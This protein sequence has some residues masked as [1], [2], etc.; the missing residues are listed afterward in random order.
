MHLQD[1]RYADYISEQIK[2]GTTTCAL[3]CKDG[4]VLAADT[5]ASAGFFIADRH[6]MK[7]QKVDRHLGMT[8]AGGVA[9]AQNLVDV[10][11]YNAN[12]YRIS[13]REL[14]PVSSAARLCSNVLFNQRYFPYYVQIILAGYDNKEGGQIYNIDLFGSMTSE[15]FI[16]TG[17]GSPVAYGYLESEYKDALSVNE[18]Y[19]IA[20][21]AVAA[22][23]RRNSGTGDN[24]NAVIIDKDG[25]RELSNEV[26]EAVGAVY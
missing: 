23:I 20:I 4:I 9:D 7:I 18:A 5:R 15:K 19:K 8:I 22:A 13:N 26:K 2:K 1:T 24:I 11:R 14:M 10:M 21:Q 17:S 12:I 3:T 25:Y 6:V 16:S